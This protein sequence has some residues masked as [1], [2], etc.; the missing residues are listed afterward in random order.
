MLHGW[1]QNVH[2]FSNRARKMT[3]RLNKAGYK[4]AFLQG[5]HRLPHIEGTSMR[6]TTI[7]T[8]ER[9]YQNNNPKD[10]NSAFSREYAYAWFLY[11]NEEDQ[12]ATDSFQDSVLKPSPSG[13]FRGMDASLD[14]LRNELRADRAEF[15]ETRTDHQEAD[16]PPFFVLGFSQGAVLV[17]KIATLACADGDNIDTNTSR[18][19]PWKDVKKCILVSGFS[20]TT[21]I[22]ENDESN[23]HKQNNE[24]VNQPDSSGTTVERRTMPS[25]HVIGRNDSRVSPSL[26]LELHDMEPCF[27][28]RKHDTEDKV[29]WEHDR[30]HVLPQDQK[31]CGRLLEFLAA[32]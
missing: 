3:K 20:F 13:N 14:F 15:L 30:G 19:E 6:T 27:C 22:R 24:M 21:S 5:P 8:N 31:F 25:F 26:T 29:L 11:D 4:V 28:G 10:N 2:V 32:P 9:E 1:A 23:A 18:L 16:I 7:D 12:S 17:H